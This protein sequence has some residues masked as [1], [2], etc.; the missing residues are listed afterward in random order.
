MKYIL[1]SLFLILSL[2]GDEIQR[3][4]SIVKD[5]TKLRVD[6]EECRK[7]L[8]DKE[9]TKMGAEI[10]SND[11]II[12]Y[13][14]LLKIKDK[15][16]ISLENKLKQ[17]SKKQI[18]IKKEYDNS[19]KFPKLAMKSQYMEKKQILEKVE[20]VKASSFRLKTDS[21][22]YDKISGTK[23]D[24]W[25]KGTSFTSNKM[26]QNWVKITG[27]FVNKKWKKAKSDMWIEKTQVLKR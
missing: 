1:I 12:K 14:E 15:K 9:I 2:Y 18:I 11:E 24:T 21:N 17:K 5:I 16:I 10:S 6:Y 7:Q 19:N 3:I 8:R 13:K 23:I 26:S 25:E 22:I 27:Y 20:L 4:E